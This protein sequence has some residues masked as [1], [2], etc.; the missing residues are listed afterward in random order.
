VYGGGEPTGVDGKSVA[1]LVG[2]F[3]EPDVDGV[4]YGGGRNIG[5]AAGCSQLVNLIN[6]QGLFRRCSCDEIVKIFF[7]Q[8]VIV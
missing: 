6:R 2:H 3:F 5:A 7:C 1:E 8:G 4:R